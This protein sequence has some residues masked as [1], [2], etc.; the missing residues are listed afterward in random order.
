MLLIWKIQQ[1][2]LTHYCESTFPILYENYS[3][4]WV[5]DVKVNPG[6]QRLHT[7]IIVNIG[8][9]LIRF[10]PRIQIQDLFSENIVDI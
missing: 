10:M 8:D 3:T 6:V 1:F 2:R 9:K 5:E 7:L 4:C